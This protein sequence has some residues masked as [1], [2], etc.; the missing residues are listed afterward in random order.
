MVS[1]AAQVGACQCQSVPLELIGVVIC[2]VGILFFFGL[3]DC[4]KTAS[5][6]QN[7][8][9]RTKGVA[10]DVPQIWD[11]MCL[12]EG[13]KLHRIPHKLQTTGLGCSGST[14]A[15]GLSILM[16][17]TFPSFPHLPLCWLTDDVFNARRFWQH[18]C[19]I[20]CTCITIVKGL[21]SYDLQCNSMT[22]CD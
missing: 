12:P 13:P 18:P 15:D 11:V 2:T 8:T 16:S 21:G 22:L 17:R 10:T 14:A 1:M 9:Y 19:H 20:L 7:S 5:C 3:D 4:I 6:M